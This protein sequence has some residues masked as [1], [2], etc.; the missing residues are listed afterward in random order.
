MAAA[1]P[2]LPGSGRSAFVLS[3]IIGLVMLG[4]CLAVRWLLQESPHALDGSAA[5]MVVA[6]PLI[7]CMLLA[8]ITLLMGL[9]GMRRKFR[10]RK[11]AR[12]GAV[13]SCML[14]ASGSGL[15]FYLNSFGVRNF[16]I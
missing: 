1:E 8:L 6:A 10:N 2:Q 11:Y 16:G 15:L 3:I 12:L 13:I 14:L 9:S 5:A 7:L 4:M